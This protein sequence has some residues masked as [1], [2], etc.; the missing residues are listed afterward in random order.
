MGLMFGETPG[1]AAARPPG[2]VPFGH[3][4]EG[5]LRSTFFC[6]STLREALT[7]AHKQLWFQPDGGGGR[8]AG[9]PTPSISG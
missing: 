4:T 3:K 6:A 5:P 2:F 7:H 9:K 1:L 8:G